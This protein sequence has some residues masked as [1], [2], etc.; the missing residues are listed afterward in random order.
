MR[1]RAR[2]RTGHIVSDLSGAHSV[3]S[4]LYAALTAWAT[5][6]IPVVLMRKV[7]SKG[8]SK[9]LKITQLVS[10]GAWI[11]M[12]SPFLCPPS[13]RLLL[14]RRKDTYQKGH[15]IWSQKPWLWPYS[16]AMTMGDSPPSPGFSYLTFNGNADVCVSSSDGWEGYM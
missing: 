16:L 10:R 8:L 3:P 5:N 7:R 11:Q 13:L 12:H 15:S 2:S 14:G 6:T 9:L 1:L 4:I